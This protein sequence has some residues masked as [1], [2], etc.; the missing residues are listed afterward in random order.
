MFRRHL[1]WPSS[2]ECCLE[3]YFTKTTK[4]MYNY[5]ILRVNMQ[6]TIYVE[7]YDTDKINFAKF[8]WVGSVHVL[9]VLYGHTRTVVVQCLQAALQCT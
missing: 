7:I 3:G 4:L 6:S 5:K 8:T 9:C 1:L 2:G